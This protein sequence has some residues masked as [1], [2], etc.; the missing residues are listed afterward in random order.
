MVF[1][2]FACGTFH[3]KNV[4]PN[5]ELCNY[6]VISSHSQAFRTLKLQLKCLITIFLLKTALSLFIPPTGAARFNAKWYR[7]RVV[8]YVVVVT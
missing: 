6:S 7:R 8:V 3:R 1:G 4:C 5:P 2:S